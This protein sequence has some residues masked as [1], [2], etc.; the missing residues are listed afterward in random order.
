MRLPDELTFAPIRR[1]VSYSPAD[2]ARSVAAGLPDGSM[3]PD[4]KDP[5]AFKIAFS[6]VKGPGAFLLRVERPVLSMAAPRDVRLAQTANPGYVYDPHIKFRPNFSAPFPVPVAYAEEIILRTM[7]ALVMFA[8]RDTPPARIDDRPCRTDDLRLLLTHEYDATTYAV[9][10]PVRRRLIELLGS[11]VP[12]DPWVRNFVLALEDQVKRNAQ[13]N[14]VPATLRPAKVTYTEDAR[15]DFLNKIST[16][17][18]LLQH[19]N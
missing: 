11:S 18:D 6:G 13:V 8:K 1:E 5:E 9:G 19:G 10:G 17:A 16:I 2:L 15:I 12:F 7:R 14:A 4:S 3:S